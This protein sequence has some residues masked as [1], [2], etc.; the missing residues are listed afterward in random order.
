[1]EIEGSIYRPSEGL[2]KISSAESLLAHETRALINMKRTYSAIW[3]NLIL[4]ILT[5]IIIRLGASVTDFSMGHL[6][7]ASFYRFIIFY[8]ILSALYNI[9]FTASNGQTIGKMMFHI[10]I[11][12]YDSKQITIKQVFAHYVLTVLGIVAATIGYFWYFFDSEGRNIPDKLVNTKIELY[13][14]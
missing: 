9:Y 8:I 10:R 3:D 14:G 2:G 13:H 12:R 7:S 6:I 11:I 5:L 4:I 1:M